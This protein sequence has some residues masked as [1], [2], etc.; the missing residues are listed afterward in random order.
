MKAADFRKCR[1]PKIQSCGRG[2]ALSIRA[3]RLKAMQK[4][5]PWV[6]EE[7]EKIRV[8]EIVLGDRDLLGTVLRLPIVYGP[9]DPVHRLHFLL[10]RMEDGRRHILFADDV[11]AFRTPRGYVENVAHAIVLAATSERAS[12]HVY[13]VAEPTTFSELEW[14]KKVA[15]V[16][17][18]DGNFVVLP[19]DRTPKHLLMPGNTAQHLVASSERIRKELGHEE[20]IPL[21]ESAHDPVG[22]GESATNTTSRI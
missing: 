3:E 2:A 6:N 10:K 1:S 16:A 14:A 13:N 5:F 20:S 19:H 17:G 18:W 9:G 4:I 22:A 12:G 11:A 7:Y 21:E 8:E 15:A